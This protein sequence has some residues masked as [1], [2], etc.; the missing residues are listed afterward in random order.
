Q[1]DHK[2]HASVFLESLL[3][4]AIPLILPADFSAQTLHA[5]WDPQAN[6]IQIRL[7]H[8]T[9]IGHTLP[10][11]ADV[12][13][14][15]LDLSY[16]FHYPRRFM[17]D[18]LVL[19]APQGHLT[20]DNPKGDGGSF[21]PPAIPLGGLPLR[22]MILRHG[23]LVIKTP[24]SEKRLEDFSATYQ[25]INPTE[26]DLTAH[27][28]FRQGQA[29]V[30]FGLQGRGTIN[31]QMLETLS[32]SMTTDQAV[33]PAPSDTSAG[34]LTLKG[35]GTIMLDLKH[36]KA[37]V[38]QPIILNMGESTLTLTAEA[39][40]QA[41]DMRTRL[42]NLP[43]KHLGPLWPDDLA[44]GGKAWVVDHI[45]EGTVPDATLT[46]SL[47][48]NANKALDVHTLNA[49][50]ALSGATIAYLPQMSPITGVQ[51]TL[52]FD[53]SGMTGTITK[54]MMGTTPLSKGSVTITGFDKDMQTIL[55]KAQLTG[56]LKNQVAEIMR[57]IPEEFK[58]A[59]LNQDTFHGDAVTALSVGFPLID[60]LAFA[61]VTLS[62]TSQIK[63][64]AM[65]HADLPL[66]VRDGNLKVTFK[67]NGLNIRGQVLAKTVPAD[68]V[69]QGDFR[70]EKAKTGITVDAVVPASEVVSYLPSMAMM[71]G[72]GRLRLEQP[73]GKQD[74]I[75]TLDA[76]DM[77]ISLTTPTFLKPKGVPL[78][79][80][81]TGTPA[82]RTFDVQGEKGSGAMGTLKNTPDGITRVR[83]DAFTLGSNDLRAVITDTQGHLTIDAT[84]NIVDLKHF[85]T[86]H[87]EGFEPPE[88][89]VDAFDLPELTLRAQSK[90]VH[91]VDHDLFGMM[92]DTQMHNDALE[93]LSL[94][95]QSKAGKPFQITLNPEGTSVAVTSEDTAFLTEA[96][97][98][99]SRLQGG[100]LKGT[101]APLTQG[102]LT[103]NTKIHA[104]MNQVTLKRAPIFS[105][106]LSLASLSGPLELLTGQ[107]MLMHTIILDARLGKETFFIDNLE[108]KNASLGVFFT[109][110]MGLNDDT[111]RGQGALVPAYA[112][113]RIVSFIPLVGSL[114]TNEDKGI[115]SISFG[116]SGKMDDPSV[117]VNPLTSFTPGALQDL[118]G[119]GRREQENKERNS[120]NQESKNQESKD[121]SNTNKARTPSRP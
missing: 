41:V 47:K 76:K 48:A 30:P 60:D 68:V 3:R 105:R 92:L 59:G 22:E 63:R 31:Q 96:L 81:I 106:I 1:M 55:I 74:S 80:T 67:N 27:G 61:D 112:L 90:V 109:G 24:T 10:V 100:T 49:T 84:A 94:S 37:T 88:S 77:G 14:V 46:V 40:P 52:G 72:A 13:R 57:A 43:V 110:Q 58:N 73:M 29:T 26:S 62:A 53:L 82:Q 64:F 45:P 9:V 15:V 85:G 39:T 93:R 107:G 91:L 89:K 113:S 54:A 50:V 4:Q 87:P 111:I 78:T 65:T 7:D 69:F 104:E 118:F 23:A 42:Q 21:S 16:G 33:V 11:Y 98:L 6:T 38:T 12:R 25:V 44:A 114:L 19:D 8:V 36:K 35:Q 103:P 20:V 75:I 115:I 83:V 18:R 70:G 86:G 121:K 117:T 99:Q 51:A 101:I 79:A 119:M 108:M 34:P 56:P 5:T 66:P 102:R 97:G 32:L 28:T 17:V 95:G 2:E 120:K 116:L 71:T